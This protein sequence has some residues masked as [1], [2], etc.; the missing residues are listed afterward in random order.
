M[1]KGRER[2]ASGSDQESDSPEWSISSPLVRTE[3][4]QKIKLKAQPEIIKDILHG[5]ISKGNE[6][7]FFRK[8]WPEEESRTVYGKSVLL[9]VCD[10]EE[11]ATKKYKIILSDVKQLLKEDRKFTKALS[12]LVSGLV[13]VD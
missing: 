11:L 1:R 9:S 10:S 8:T 4:S 7:V 5:A 13:G 3:G 6:D 12:D 2:V